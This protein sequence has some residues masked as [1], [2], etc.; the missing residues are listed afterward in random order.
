M[1]L[2]WEDGTLFSAAYLS[3]RWQAND[4]TC[5][6]ADNPAVL[7][8]HSDD[9]E[10]VDEEIDDS[11]GAQLAAWLGGEEEVSYAKKDK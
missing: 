3:V 5:P 4:L 9:E 6:D 2:Y 8:D 7:V 1:L 10:E 11:A